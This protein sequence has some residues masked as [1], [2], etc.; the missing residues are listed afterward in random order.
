MPGKKLKK[1]VKQPKFGDEIIRNV[2]NSMDKLQHEMYLNYVTYFSPRFVIEDKLQHEMYLNITV[3][4]FIYPPFSDKL[5]H[6]MYLNS[7]RR[8]GCGYSEPIN[9]NMRCI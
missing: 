5:Q 7:L 6:E 8:R 4:G 9:F 2:E 3:P 1:Y